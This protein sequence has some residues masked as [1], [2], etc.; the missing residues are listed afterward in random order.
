LLSQ[1]HSNVIPVGTNPPG[2]STEG[3]AG[4]S[5]APEAAGHCQDRN[6]LCGFTIMYRLSHVLS[7]KLTLYSILSIA[8]LYCTYVLI[9]QTHGCVYEANPI[10]AVWL[11]R[12]GWHGLAWFK[13][14]AVAF[15][16]GVAA[17]ISHYR[18]RAG[19]FVLKFGCGAMI[20]VIVYSWSIMHVLAGDLN[21]KTDQVGS[22]FAISE[23]TARLP[24]SGRFRSRGL[25][26]GQR[27]V[28]CRRRQADEPRHS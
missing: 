10:A 7:A 19:D 14:L 11:S 2:V 28:R 22:S 21:R 20:V 16:A 17:I 24:I 8:D 6:R 4:D 18:P 5:A 26:P 25:M 12:F 9:Q 27:N 15:V 1:I 23:M 13:G 3:L